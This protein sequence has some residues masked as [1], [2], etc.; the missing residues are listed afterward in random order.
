MFDIIK[1]FLISFITDLDN[2][3]IYSSIIM[4][5]PPLLFTLL[6]ISLLSINRVIYVSFFH[7]I[8]SIPGLDFIIGLIILLI[9][10]KM[11]TKEVEVSNKRS[12]SP[13]KLIFTIVVLD[14]FLAVDGVILTAEVS[15]ENFFIFV[16]IFI[17]LMLLMLCTPIIFT[18]LQ[19]FPWFYL[20]A[21]TF[22]SFTAMEKITNDPFISQ[23]ILLLAP[24]DFRLDLMIS[25]I[26]SILIFLYGLRYWIKRNKIYSFN[27]KG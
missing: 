2:I 4:R 1:V 13:L 25:F 24:T 11:S 16:G 10:V 27:A 8:D 17:S 14:M 21:G 6:L 19:F 20:I 18:L 12:P 3:V 15:D 9:A 22:I 26:I 5:K 23:K 7:T